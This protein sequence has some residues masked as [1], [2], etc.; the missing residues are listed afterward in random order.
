[1]TKLTEEVV[2]RWIK[3]G[4]PGELRDIRV[5]MAELWRKGLITLRWRG[6]WRG[7]RERHRGG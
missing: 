2:E 6:G 3:R 4:G 5:A 1:M 7:R